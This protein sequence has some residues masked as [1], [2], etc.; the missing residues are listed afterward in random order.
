M[1][2]DDKDDKLAQRKRE[3]EQEL[4][5]YAQAGISSPNVVK[6][7]RW[8]SRFLYLGMAALVAYLLI[9]GWGSVSKDKYE[10]AVKSANDFSKKAK[11]AQTRADDLESRLSF[12]EARLVVKTGELESERA[13]AT[14]AD[15]LNEQ[16][17]ALIA[18]AFGEKAYAGHWREKLE[19][20]TPD[21]HGVDPVVGAKALLR[22]ASV[23]PAAMR[24]ELLR[25]T[26]D[27]GAQAC[28]QAASELLKDPAPGV[29]V[30]AA[31]LLS[32]LHG[33][34]ADEKLETAARAE[35]EPQARRD[36]WFAWS[37]QALRAPPAGE[38]TPEAW[39]GYTVRQADAPVDDLFDAYTKAPPEYKGALLALMAEAAGPGY[40]PQ[41]IGV[42]T[43]QERTPAER[44]IAVRWC[45]ERKEESARAV[46]TGL[47]EGKGPVAPEAAKALDAI[48]R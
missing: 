17:R 2:E 40:A 13:G 47:S 5:A 9:S 48:G 28:A 22:Q 12:A 16:A 36:I 31:T 38:W 46:L 18:R 6:V 32:R 33:A 4:E 25:E 23:A 7:A 37:V 15:R 21:A 26:V 14:A 39:V 42:A 3:L 19:G 24:F 10:T 45:G 20:V 35:L 30:A 41:F 27:F 44:I 8:V 1:P 34:G 29:R 43:A 11:E